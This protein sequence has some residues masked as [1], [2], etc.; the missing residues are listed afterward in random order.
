[1]APT[2]SDPRRRQQLAEARAIRDFA[3]RELGLPDND[4]YRAC[5][6]LGRPH[7]VWHVFAAPECCLHAKRWCLLEVACVSYRGY[8]D[9]RDAEQLAAKLRHQ[10]VTRPSSAACLRHSRVFR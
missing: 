10:E 8:C 6:D 3:R 9:R 2:A 5:A 1:M 7:M 4:S